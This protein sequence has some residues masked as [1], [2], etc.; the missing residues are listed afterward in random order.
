MLTHSV[1]QP[2]VQICR[3]GGVSNYDD[4]AQ[5]SPTICH[6]SEQFDYKLSTELQLNGVRERLMM[7]HK[8]LLP[9]V[10]FSCV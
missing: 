6:V 10:T 8:Y 5:I 7:R 1:L 3:G 2:N 9:F 4:E